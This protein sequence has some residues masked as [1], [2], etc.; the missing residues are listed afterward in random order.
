[1][2]SSIEKEDTLRPRLSPICPDSPSNTVV[3]VGESTFTMVDVADNSQWFDTLAIGVLPRGGSD[4]PK[5]FPSEEEGGP[6]TWYCIVSGFADLKLPNGS[7]QSLQKFD[8]VYFPPGSG[9]DLRATGDDPLSWLAVSSWGG[10]PTP[11]SEE[12]GRGRSLEGSLDSA[13]DPVV[14]YRH[15]TAPRQWPGNELGASPKPWWYYTVVD[16]S[17]WYH[18]AC[19]SCIPPGGASTFH[20]HMLDFEGPYETWYIVVRG[21]ALIRNEYEDFFFPQGPAGVFVPCDASHQMVNNGDDFLWYLTISS[22]GS[23]P[24]V[25]NTYDMP[26]G[27]DRPGYLDEYKRIMQTRQEHGLPTP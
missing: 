24:L 10:R 2:T 15:L 9:A 1:M 17:S 25:L 4:G 26:S 8:A 20:T 19:I 16:Q 11:Y 18:T 23:A 3:Q 7:V 5:V 21:S 13:L 27:V 14:F 12:G 22:R 6:E